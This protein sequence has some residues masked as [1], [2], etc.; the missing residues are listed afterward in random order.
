VQAVLP[1]APALVRQDEPHPAK[2]TPIGTRGAVH[3]P[4]CRCSEV[5]VKRNSSQ[6]EATRVRAGG[7]QHSP[8]PSPGD[9]A[10]CDPGALDLRAWG[11]TSSPS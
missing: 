8:H 11:N 1:R 3:A 10:R 2:P 4:L 9:A 6:K 7:C 5:Q